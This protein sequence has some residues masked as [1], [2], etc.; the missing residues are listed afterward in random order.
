MG[1]EPDEVEETQEFSDENEKD[2]FDSYDVD[3]AFI[4]ESAASPSAPNS[5]EAKGNQLVKDE[6]AMNA[7]APSQK[8]TD[9]DLGES[10]FF[11]AIRI[12][13]P[14]QKNI[15][16]SQTVVLIGEFPEL[17]SIFATHFQIMFKIKIFI[18]RNKLVE[19][20]MSSNLIFYLGILVS[21]HLCNCKIEC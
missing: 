10:V 2:D 7:K 21:R 19:Q 17:V 9:V 20:Q 14:F 8:S 3:T 16:K 4:G 13:S 5:E 15:W 1:L 6:P 18:Y 12:L 11:T